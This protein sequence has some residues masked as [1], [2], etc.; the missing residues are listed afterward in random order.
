MKHIK[1]MVSILAIFLL[2]VPLFAQTNEEEQAAAQHILCY[3]AATGEESVF[4]SLM[5][6]NPLM[7]LNCACDEKGHTPLQYATAGEFFPIVE[8]LVKLG[9]TIDPLSFKV[10]ISI[11]NFDI[12]QL[13][14][15]EGADLCLKL[16]NSE[17]GFPASRYAENEEMKELL[18]AAEKNAD[19]EKDAV[20]TCNPKKKEH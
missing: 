9:A 4:F 7:D 20:G 16:P 18:I 3:A 19:V 11:N 15:D 13:F 14:I 1:K 17:R 6:S 8:N 5:L 2:A 10:A 12:V